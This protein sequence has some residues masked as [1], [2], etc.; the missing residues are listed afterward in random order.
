MST[1]DTCTLSAQK[2]VS[3]QNKNETERTQAFSL[4]RISRSMW[5]VKEPPCTL[6]SRIAVTDSSIQ[7]KQKPMQKKEPQKLV[8]ELSR[9]QI[10]PSFQ[11]RVKTNPETVHDYEDLMRDGV[12][13][14]PLFV[15]QIVD[16]E[17]EIVHSDERLYLVDGFHRFMAFKNV[18]PTANKITV[19]FL[20]QTK[21]DASWTSVESNQQHG[22]RR[23]NEDKVRCVNMA[24]QISGSEDM[25]DRE[26][27]KRVGVSHEFVRQQRNR[28][29]SQE[30][31]IDDTPLDKCE[32]SK[33]SGDFSEALLKFKTLI[34]KIDAIKKDML[35]LSQD[36]DGYSVNWIAMNADASNA[37]R[38]LVD[39]MPHATCCYCS[40]DGCDACKNT[41]WLGLVSYEMAPKNLKLNGK[42]Q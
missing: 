17:G 42:Q 12:I 10:L 25:S 41:G 15:V 38:C 32:S 18:Y 39:A 24:L 26:I 13:F 27:A 35:L 6:I 2:C 5:L 37:K 11:S 4:K 19:Q 36:T 16:D 1:V 34:K 28:E 23:T 8:V 9:I 21:T 7:K 14:P 20:Q 31:E 3:P 33:E 40:G 29:T 30:K 22:L